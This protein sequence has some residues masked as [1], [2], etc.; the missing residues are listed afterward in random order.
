M[1][2]PMS[3]CNGGYKQEVERLR[4]AGVA[5]RNGRLRDLFDYLAERG[6]EAESA[7]QADIAVAVFGEAQNDADDATVRVYVH[8]LRKKID[9]YYA[10][11]EPSS[12]EMRLEIPSGI[13]GLRP[14][15][16]AGA[17]NPSEET[18]AP[19]LSR[20]LLILALVA[21]V[22][23]CA[24]AFG[25]GRSLERPGAANVLW[26][27]LLQ[28]ERPV[29]LVLGDYYLF[30]EIDPLA[31]EEGR[32][33]R[34]FRVNSSED[35]LRLQEAEPKRYA[36]AEDF[37]LNYLP[38]SSSY[39]LTSVSPL[40][41]GNGKSANVIA[42]SELMPEMLSR[43]DIVYVG[44]LSGLGSL[45]QQVFA[46]SGFRLGETYDELI[47]RDSRQIYAT[48]E[49]R[50]IAAPVFYRDYAY[51]ARF[52]APGGAKVMVVASERET[53]L[54]ALGP[55]VAKATL[56]DEVAK[57]AGGDA[58]FE[59]LWQVTGQQGADLSDRLILARTRR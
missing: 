2:D 21:L 13:Y 22:V 24:G 45:E 48:D 55:I 14:I 11:H 20:R 28:S 19:P 32:L 58:P 23:L 27:P 9:D 37:G 4:E 17:A 12:D 18:A 40:L 34:D 10:R 49:A 43:F 25:L 15:H 47:D 35:L 44:L 26:Q 53:G 38:F 42:A 50:R 30:G 51:L 46:G 29:L 54:R 6:P 56:P 52:T 59:A 33:I 7:S 41:V 3:D 8:R 31:P 39:A 36:M 5:G 1:T 16:R 57:V